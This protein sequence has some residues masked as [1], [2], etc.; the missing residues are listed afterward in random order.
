MLAAAAIPP[1]FVIARHPHLM[2]FGLPY[3]KGR[4]RRWWMEDRPARELHWLEAWFDIS[5]GVFV[6]EL[7]V[8]LLGGFV[9]LLAQFAF[10]TVLTGW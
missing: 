9:C 5:L 3:P 10:K 2:P 7:V 4:R 1:G 8:C 6:V